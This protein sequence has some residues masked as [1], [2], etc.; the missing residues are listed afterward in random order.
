MA[1]KRC[2]PDRP[3]VAQIGVAESASALASRE[4]T[5]SDGTLYLIDPSSQPGA[6][7]QLSEKD[8]ES[9]CLR[10]Q[11]DERSLD[12]AIQFRRCE[13]VEQTHRLPFHSWRSF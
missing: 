1:L 4:V 10:L 3:W 12:R 5:P 2:A 7:A 9:C 8:S 6:P 13:I 11:N